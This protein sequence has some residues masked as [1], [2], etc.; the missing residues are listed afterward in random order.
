MGI[1][2]KKRGSAVDATTA[3]ST[4]TAV[5]AVAAAAAA[6]SLADV[7]VP[8]PATCPPTNLDPDPVAIAANADASVT[9]MTNNFNNKFSNIQTMITFYNTELINSKNTQELYDVYLI[10]NK[11]LDGNI[12]EVHND[13]LTNDRKTYYE[14]G[15][16][17]VLVNWN[18]FFL[19][20]YFA[21]F[22]AFILG[23]VFSEN[24]IPK[25]QSISLAILL[26]LYPFIISPIVQKLN[27]WVTYMRN[28]YPK[29]VYNSL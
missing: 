19:Y 5:A 21:L 11:D 7:P 6:N 25:Y 12:K 15:A 1:F 3:T 8:P 10:K 28:L 29:N 26:G 14:M 23:I 16:L 24:T 2:K 18:H 20:M 17:E 27:T 13:V 9:L 4:S 22:F